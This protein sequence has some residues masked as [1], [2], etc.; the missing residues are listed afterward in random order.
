MHAVAPRCNQH[1][2]TI[3]NRPVHVFTLLLGAIAQLPRL[4][5]KSSSACRWSINSRPLLGPGFHLTNIIGT[6]ASLSIYLSAYTHLRLPSPLLII[7]EAC[8]HRWSVPW[9]A[10]R[11]FIASACGGSNN[12]P[13]TYM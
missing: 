5:R 2:K 12:V 11:S 1:G 3:C 10:S 7:P 4:V 13:E 8:R 6:L 9:C